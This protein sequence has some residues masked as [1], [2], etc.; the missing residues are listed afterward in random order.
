MRTLRVILAAAVILGTGAVQADDADIER[1]DAIAWKVL[2]D[3][4]HLNTRVL[5]KCTVT[6][7][8][9]QDGDVV[10]VAW[11]EY[12]V[13][14]CPGEDPEIAFLIARMKVDVKTGAVL[15]DYGHADKYT[16][17]RPKRKAK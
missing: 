3:R 13:R 11:R 8:E 17:L 10:T 12:W 5:R 4:G 14:G 6:E 15:W 7:G 16:P 2:R 1:A 9:S